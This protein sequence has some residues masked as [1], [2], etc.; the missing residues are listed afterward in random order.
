MMYLYNN[1]LVFLSHFYFSSEIYKVVIRLNPL[2]SGMRMQRN[3]SLL[4]RSRA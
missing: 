3:N 4:M 1:V 2:H